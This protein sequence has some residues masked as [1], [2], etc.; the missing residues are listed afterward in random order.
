MKIIWRN[1]KMNVEIKKTVKAGNSSAVI[2]PRA[3]LNQE[4]RVELVRK[5]P[6]TI[7]LDVINI[8]KKYLSLKEIVGIYIV[9]SYARG[10]QE[11]ESDVDILVI[12][13]NT[14]R[15][16]IEEGIYNI[17]IVSKSL[18]KYKLEKNL[19]PI[20]SMIKEAEPL[21]NSDYLDS[22]EVNITKKNVKWYIDTTKKK[23]EIVKDWLENTKKKVENRV[24]YTLVLRIRTL[25]IIE[26]MIKNKPY[27]KKEFVK[28]IRKISGSK[29]AY[30]SYLA[31]KNNSEEDN[32]TEKEEA[33]RLY[34]YLKKQLDRVKK[35]L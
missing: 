10:E 8:V 12:S 16:M 14:D 19:F 33:W 26:K 13:E 30:E 29:N 2:L 34:S 24:I 5:T 11:R 4:V 21:I 25:Y 17:L 7:L 20:G 3:W 1:I 22:L 28:L 9:G 6:E 35:L 18:L 23:L 15:E 31:I 27:S 32:K